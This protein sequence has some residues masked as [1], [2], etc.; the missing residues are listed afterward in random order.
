[1]LQTPTLGSCVEQH[2]RISTFQSEPFWTV[3]PQVAKHGQRCAPSQPAEHCCDACMQRQR[4]SAV[5][6]GVREQLC[7][8]SAPASLWSSRTVL[9]LPSR[10]LGP[11]GCP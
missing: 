3:R 8:H 9:C 2:Q 1:M 5:S 10:A 7:Q 11:Q 4:C 6:R